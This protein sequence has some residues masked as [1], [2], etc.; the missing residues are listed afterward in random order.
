MIKFFL[1]NNRMFLQFAKQKGFTLVETL[2][3]LS[4]FSLSV[5]ALLVALGGGLKGTNFAKSK[6]IATYLA[7][8]G[9]ELMR[10][11]RDTFVLYDGGGNGWPEFLAHVN[12]CA[13]NSKGCIF[14]T[15]QIVYGDPEKPITE[16]DLD[17]CSSFCPPLYFHPSTGAYDY[18][19][20]ADGEVSGFRRHIRIEIINAHEARV[21]S[22]VFFGEENNSVGFVE[23][24]FDWN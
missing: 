16:I 3:A 18:L 4:I 24:I 13:N 17:A 6:M 22:F 15:E 2:V 23:N 7:E 1:K 20:G 19:I 10:N 8:E 11:M 14:H 9:I 5:I 21:H 12:P